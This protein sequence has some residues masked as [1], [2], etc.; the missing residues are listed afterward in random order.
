[1]IGNAEHH[2]VP[3]VEDWNR[4]QVNNGE[5]DGQH[6]QEAYKVFCPLFSRL[7]R[8]LSNT[9]RTTQFFC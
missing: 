3:T 4:Q 8:H 1:M 2:Q 9:Q 5:V 7:T 6:R